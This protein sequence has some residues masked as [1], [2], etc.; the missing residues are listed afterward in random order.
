MVFKVVIALLAYY[1]GKSNMGL[2]DFLEIIRRLL[3]NDE[4]QGKDD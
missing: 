3:R 2:D 1:L 4:E